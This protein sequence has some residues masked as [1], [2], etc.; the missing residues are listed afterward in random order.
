MYMYRYM[1]IFSYMYVNTYMI[2]VHISSMVAGWRGIFVACGRG[3]YT[4]ICMY[5]DGCYAHIKYN[6]RAERRIVACRREIL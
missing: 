3:T 2:Y 4:Y 1:Y 5:G 6:P